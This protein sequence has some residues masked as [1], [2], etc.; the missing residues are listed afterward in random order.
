[1]KTFTL[2]NLEC[3]TNGASLTAL[4]CPFPKPIIDKKLKEDLDM[5]QIHDTLLRKKMIHLKKYGHQN[6]L[7]SLPFGQ[8][9]ALTHTEQHEFEKGIQAKQS[10]TKLIFDVCP[11]CQ[12]CHLTAMRELLVQFGH[13]NEI[14]CKPSCGSCANKPKKNTTQ[15]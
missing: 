13:T 9:E 4:E 14:Q 6:P 7:C 2:L 1:V 15:K 5:H 11:I 8:Y 12:G 10:W 3:L